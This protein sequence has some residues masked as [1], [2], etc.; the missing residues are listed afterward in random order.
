MGLLDGLFETKALTRGSRNAIPRA[1]GSSLVRSAGSGNPL[2]IPGQW[3]INQAIEYAMDQVMWVFR[4]VDV[5]AENQSRVPIKLRRG[6]DVAEGEW[7][8][9]PSLFKLLNLRAN[10]YESA[11][12]F[13]Y[14]LSANLLLS[15]RGAFVEIVRDQAGNAR[16]LHILP[17]GT[18]N[19]IPDPKKFVSGYRVYRS[20]NAYDDLPPENVIWFKAKPHPTDPYQQMTPLT[21]LGISVETDWLAHQ[22]N[23]TYLQNGGRQGL[24]IALKGQV[25]QEDAEEIKRRFSGGPMRAGEATVIEGDGIDVKD[26]S[27]RPTDVQWSELM[28]TSKDEILMGFG[29]PESVMGNAA[30]RTYDNADAER[31][32]FWQDTM[33]AHCTAIAQGLD[34]LTGSTDD[35]TVLAYDYATIDVLQRTKRRDRE[36][37]RSEVSAGLRTA[38]EYRKA[39]GYDEVDVPGVGVLINNSLGVA[40]MPEDE[41][42]REKITSTLVKV[43]EPPAGEEEGSMGMSAL[44][45]G[46]GDSDLSARIPTGDT[47]TDDGSDAEGAEDDWYEKSIEEE[48]EY[49]GPIVSSRDFFTKAASL[50]DGGERPK[51]DEAHPYLQ[52]A[53][54]DEKTLEGV[55]L[56]W[57]VQ[58][59]EII[60]DRLS[61]AK[62]RKG[63]RFWEYKEGEEPTEY[64]ALDAH[65]AVDP[66][67]WVQ[68]LRRSSSRVI[69]RT[70]LR[71]ARRMAREITG[72]RNKALEGLIPSGIDRGAILN[73]AEDQAMDL[74]ERAANAQ[75]ARVMD[76]INTMAD[77]GAS[78]A[79]IE[80][81]VR[82]TIGAR[83]SWRKR[84][85]QGAVQ[86]ASEGV[87]MGVATNSGRKMVKFWI[88]QHDDR[89]RKWHRKAHGQRRLGGS[90]FRVGPAWLRYPGDPLGPPAL[91]IGCRCYV[92]W[93]V[94]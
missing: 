69:Y 29:V 40:F 21:S 46:S 53:L 63:T 47:P 17:A 41:D 81:E 94:V 4:C 34:I 64:K 31:E 70:V 91:V 26:M 16:E 56:A 3:D 7:L 14:R 42:E 55:L 57:D 36:E 10:K 85:V 32:N 38:G 80:K 50:K 22:F 74:I 58:Q 20:D 2:P 5:I 82:R 33:V 51:G 87:R 27:G 59:E 84:V 67:R 77:E 65:Y 30:G 6:L 25:S 18:T 90:R 8:D 45:M 76:K 68:D 78:L 61:H 79:E 54:M 43:G 23:R 60:A 19:P 92:H 39:A 44:G 11:K 28:S 49:V 71:E 24:L 1:T 83:S 66:A 93:S 89:V 62:L 13:R 73:A 86:T 88:A 52:D 75:L 35:D 15:R 48:V 9:D 37:F 72:Q 12:D